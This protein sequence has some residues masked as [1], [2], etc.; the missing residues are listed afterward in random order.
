[1]ASVLRLAALHAWLTSADKSLGLP[2]SG[3]LRIWGV[4]YTT[5]LVAI[6]LPALFLLRQRADRVAGAEATPA[7]HDEWL[8][9]RGLKVSIPEALPRIVALLAPILAADASKL[10]NLF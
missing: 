1:V 8:A 5:L 7:A 6:Y 2:T 3:L 4:F 10:L 9:K